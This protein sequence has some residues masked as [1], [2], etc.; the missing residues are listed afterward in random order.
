[1][2]KN[3]NMRYPI[4]PTEPGGLLELAV[5][6]VKAPAAAAAPAPALDV[7]DV[8]DPPLPPVTKASPPKSSDDETPAD[9]ESDKDKSSAITNVLNIGVSVVAVLLFSLFYM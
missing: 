2:Q 4:L 5:D 6:D 1:M 7:E 8:V 3:E 9:S